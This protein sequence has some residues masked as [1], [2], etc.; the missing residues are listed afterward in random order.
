MAYTTISK[1]SLHFTNLLRTGTYGNGQTTTDFATLGFTPD[2]SWMK[3]RNTAGSHDQADIVRG[4][5]QMLKTDSTAMQ[6][7]GGA[8]TSFITNGIRVTTNNDWGSNINIVHHFWK[9]GGAASSNSDGSV[10]ANVSANQSSGVSIASFTGTESAITVGHG[11]GVAPSVFIIRRYTDDGYSSTSEWYFYHKSLASN[12]YLTLQ[13]SAATGTNDGSLWNTSTPV[14]DSVINI[15]NNANSNHSGTSVLLYSFAEKKGFSKFGSYTGNGN[16]D[17]PFI[18]TGFKPAF[19]ITKNTSSVNNWT[20]CD[21]KRST[22]NPNNTVLNPNVNSAEATNNP[23]DFL[24]N[25]FKI[26]GTEG[27]TNTSGNTYIYMAFAE[28]PLVANVGQS[29]PATAK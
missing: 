24:S 7:A 27:N 4:A 19:L 26:R 13:S 3:P 9:L 18:Y 15:G 12:K 21:N 29:I 25:G 6:T 14:T 8:V 11:L 28:E 2:W 16:A 20:M 23:Q 1:P 5:G 22:F 17:G 10:T